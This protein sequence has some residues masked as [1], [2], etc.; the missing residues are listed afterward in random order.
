MESYIRVSQTKNKVVVKMKQKV[1]ISLDEK[2][3]EEVDRKLVS[4]TFRNRSHLV[5]YAVKRLLGEEK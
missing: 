4:A 1:S 5:E 2:T 3:V